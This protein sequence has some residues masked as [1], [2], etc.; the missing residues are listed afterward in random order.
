MRH[1]LIALENKSTKVIRATA[2]P[3]K[4]RLIMKKFA[5]KQFTKKWTSLPVVII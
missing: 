2:K 3:R 5:K 1:I 4:E